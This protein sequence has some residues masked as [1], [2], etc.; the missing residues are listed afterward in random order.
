LT[1]SVR[2]L[3]FPHGNCRRF[4]EFAQ[5]VAALGCQCR[6]RLR[7]LV[8]GIGGIEVRRIQNEKR[9]TFRDFLTKLNLE[10]RDAAGN[11]REDFDETG[12]IGLDNGRKHQ[13][14][15]HLLLR[16]GF[17]RQLRSQ[18]RTVRNDDPY[19]LL[20]ELRYILDKSP[21]GLSTRRPAG[22]SICESA[23]SRPDQE[24]GKHRCEGA[25]ALGFGSHR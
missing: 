25:G 17:D 20:D 19:S 13:V 2:L 9:L 10:L 12:G 4:H 14:A 16:H 24:Y 18:R 1:K 6:V 11:R 8:I 5:P 21:G 23:E 7:S 15:L 22:E 3:Q